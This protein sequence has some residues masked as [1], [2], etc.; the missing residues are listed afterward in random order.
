MASPTIQF[1]RGAFVNLP[2][3]LA[4]EPGFTTDFYDLYVGTVGV[5][6][7]TNQFFGSGRYWER[8]TTS[9]AAKLRLFEASSNGTDNIT[10]QAPNNLAGVG[11]FIFP[12]TNDGQAGDALVITG[13][14]NGVY[15]LEWAN[16]TAGAVSGISVRDE[17]GAALPEGASGIGSVVTVDF[18]GAGVSAAFD[19]GTQSGVA[20][21]RVYTASATQEGTAR[22]DSSDFIVTSGLVELA[23]N[24]T[25]TDATF[26]SINVT[27]VSTFTTVDATTIDTTSINVTGISTLFNVNVGGALTVTGLTDLNGGLDV[28]GST[29]LNNNLSVAGLSTFTGLIDAN[30]G[31]DAAGTS[32]FVDVNVTGVTTT[33]TLN[34]TGNTTIG[35]TA[36]NTLT[37]NA[38]STFNAP[39][40]GTISTATRSTLV[41]TTLTTANAE[42]YP[43]FVD[44]N[45]SATGETIR[46]DSDGLTYNPSTNVLTVPT[47]DVVNIRHTNDTTALTIDTSGNVTA[48]QNV[49]ISGSL[50]VNGTTTQVNT[51]TLTV[52]DSLI[53]IGYVNGSPP[54]SDLNI[55]LG[56]ILGWYDT[57]VRRAAVFWDDSAG[58]I[59]IAQNVTEVSSVLTVAAWASVEMG[60]VWMNDTAGQNAV[61][62]YLAADTL[63]TG[64]TAG[65]YLQ[66]IVVD[67][68]EF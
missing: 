41:D 68:G 52:E 31:I 10:F 63:Y 29:V 36:G 6:T 15:T 49:T 34:V 2:D 13:V 57:E 18:V 51:T 43:V 33:V 40:T 21:V 44:T 23:P 48:A 32:T 8:E 59:A 67:G 46:V 26:T 30:G 24:I 1:K 38:T 7:T 60:Q 61:M 25:F 9:N 45:A 20:T 12:N 53:D 16:A 55:D 27:G 37:V 35:D 66:N 19:N 58:R 4:G 50:F 65:R 5:G 54:V 64:Q 42:Y 22:F 56:I 14:T 17:G 47:L 62:S 28:T 39:I 11:T 3:L